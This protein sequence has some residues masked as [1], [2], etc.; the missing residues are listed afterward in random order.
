VSCSFSLIGSLY[1]SSI[2]FSREQHNKFEC[3]SKTEWLEWIKVSFVIPLR[4][5]PFYIQCLW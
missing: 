4:H 3:L 2:P 1:L 5:V